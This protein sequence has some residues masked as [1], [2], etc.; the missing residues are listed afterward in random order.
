MCRKCW[1]S[2][3]SR[4]LGW[5][6]EPRRGEADRERLCVDPATGHRPARTGATRSER[7]LEVASDR[8]PLCSVGNRLPGRTDGGG[9]EGFDVPHPRDF[10]L[11]LT[12]F[13]EQAQLLCVGQYGRELVPVCQAESEFLPERPRS[14]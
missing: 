7:L 9:A 14:A 1:P 3:L 6:T 2:S 8:R 13:G 12:R 4:A 5:E 10:S 11:E